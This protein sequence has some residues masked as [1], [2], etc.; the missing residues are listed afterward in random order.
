MEANKNKD[1]MIKE[2]VEDK[3]K[4][5]KIE[6]L[7]EQGDHNWFCCSPLGVCSNDVSGMTGEVEAETMSDIER[8]ENEKNRRLFNQI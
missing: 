8:A 4:L 5:T 3:K 2:S 1:N 7:Y 6:V